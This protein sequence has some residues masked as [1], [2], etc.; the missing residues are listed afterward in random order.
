MLG[1]DTVSTAGPLSASLT[2]L[3]WTPAGKR[4]RRA[5][6]HAGD[7]LVV[8]GT[9]GDAGLGLAVLTDGLPGLGDSE[10]TALVERHRLP[11]PRLALRSALRNHANA[12]AD[13]SDGL[14][15]DACHVAEASGLGLTVWLERAPVSAEAAAW[16]ALQPDPVAARMT[17]VTSGDDYEVVG[18][19]APDRLAAFIAAAAESGVAITAVGEV[20]ELP[21]LALTFHGEPLAVDRRGWMHV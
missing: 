7:I 5:G 3:G 4:V 11:T 21:G 9:I 16:L 10:R 14:L 12:A 13:V 8:S 19:V 6:A 20:C 2:M 1:G 15:A 18:A 17:L